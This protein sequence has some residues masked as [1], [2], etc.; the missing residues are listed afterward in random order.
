[1]LSVVPTHKEPGAAFL[2]LI[3]I[4][5]LVATLMIPRRANGR[6]YR[7][8]RLLA[9]V[10][11]IAFFVAIL[12][13]FGVTLEVVGHGV[14]TVA[15]AVWHATPWG[16]EHTSPLPAA[17]PTTSATTATHA[18]I[19]TI[20]QGLAS[21]QFEE[22]YNFPSSATRELVDIRRAATRAGILESARLSVE[23]R[24]ACKDTL[25]RL[26]YIESGD[27]FTVGASLGWTDGEEQV[28]RF[29]ISRVPSTPPCPSLTIYA[30]VMG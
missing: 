29:W 14:S 20:P 6:R 7:W 10:L 13:I 1:M 5:V 3:I 9:L 4:V 12:A 15:V 24:T 19:Q 18:T 17:I 26:E 30:E 28:A 16:G 11:L 23:F 2:A 27:V 21:W 25:F 8:V 22:S